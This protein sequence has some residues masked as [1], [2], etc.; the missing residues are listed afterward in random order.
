MSTAMLAGSLIALAVARNTMTTSVQTTISSCIQTKK[1]N[2]FTALILSSLNILSNRASW[3][4]YFITVAIVVASILLGWII[5]MPLAR[6]RHSKKYIDHDVAPY[7]FKLLRGCMLMFVL[8]FIF[9]AINI[10]IF[11]PFDYFYSMIQLDTSFVCV[12]TLSAFHD[13]VD[14]V[15]QSLVASLVLGGLACVWGFVWSLKSVSLYATFVA[16][17]SIT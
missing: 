12:T 2:E 9:S 16:K 17:E 3:I 8:Y 5:I 4:V 1:G 10:T 6:T 14:F 11:V 15:W 7:W 13:S